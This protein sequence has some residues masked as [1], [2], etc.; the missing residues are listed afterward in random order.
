[1]EKF[2]VAALTPS[3]TFTHSGFENEHAAEQEAIRMAKSGNFGDVTVYEAQRCVRIE[4][5]PV[6]FK[7]D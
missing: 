7:P 5:Q 4:P 2:I 3:G 1:M 6:W